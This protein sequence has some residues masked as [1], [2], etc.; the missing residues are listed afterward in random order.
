MS[1]VVLLPRGRAPK[2]GWPVVTWGHGTAGIADK[3]AP[4]RVG[5]R[6]SDYAREII[7][8]LWTGYLKAGYAVVQTDFEGLG[9]PGHHPFLIGRSEA[10]G[11]LDIVLAAR[12]FDPRVGRRVLVAGHSQGG[13]AALWTA[14]EAPRWTPSLKVIGTQLF[15][16]IGKASPLAA[17]R[18]SLTNPGGLAPYAALVLRAFEVVERDFSVTPFF[19]ERA[20]E[21]YPHTIERCVSDLGREDSFGGIS[22]ADM[23]RDDA[24]GDRLTNLLVKY[25]DAQTLKLR[26][27]V[28][29]IHGTGDTTLPVVLSDILADDL[30]EAGTRVTYKRYEGETHSGVVARSRKT[31][32]ADAR[33]RLR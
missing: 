14:G 4:S 27:R 33:R 6:S 26:R 8:P 31:A 24:D 7:S 17:V 21:L 30:R 5:L 1:G 19:T 9:T 32:L 22:V 15:A 2:G 25:V 3:C 20:L 13:H 12:Q 18:E 28:L 16:P 11:M 29:L 23:F 10:R